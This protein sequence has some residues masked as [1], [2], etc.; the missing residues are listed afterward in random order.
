[1]MTAMVDIERSSWFD[2]QMCDKRRQFSVKKSLPFVESIRGVYTHRVRHVTVYTGEGKSH[3]AITCWCGMSICISSRKPNRLVAEPSNGRKVC[4]TCE[5]RVVG[6]GAAGLQ[7]INGRQV[8]YT[9][10]RAS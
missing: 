7:E 9:P 4:A 5:G 10:R 3:M 2:H 8:K 6:A 1:M